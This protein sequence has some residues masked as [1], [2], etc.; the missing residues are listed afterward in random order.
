LR[1]DLVKQSPTIVANDI[2]I[3]VRSIRKKC[4]MRIAAQ[5]VERRFQAVRTLFSAFRWIVPSTFESVGCG[6]KLGASSYRAGIESFAGQPAHRL[7][8]HRRLR[9]EKRA[10]LEMLWLPCPALLQMYLECFA[11]KG[12]LL[13]SK[14]WHLRA[15]AHAR[16]R[17]WLSFGHRR[18]ASPPAWE[19]LIQV[20][21]HLMEHLN[22]FGKNE[23]KYPLMIGFTGCHTHTR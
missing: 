2:D 1:S 3:E 20:E 10:Q 22:L 17:D 9:Y 23:G 14:Q 18:L 12:A 13:R 21:T 8:I 7:G 11:N 4:E 19:F 16:N 6:R 5:P 15:I